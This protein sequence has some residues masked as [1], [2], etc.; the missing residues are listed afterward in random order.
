MDKLL[1]AIKKSLRAVTHSRYFKT[2][3][4][5]QGAF[6]AQLVQCL[7]SLQIEGAII[8]EEYQKRMRDHGIII[9]PDIIVHVPFDPTIHKS[10]RQGNFV[11]FELKLSPGE[12]QAQEDYRHLASMCEV[13]NYPP[14]E[15]S[16]I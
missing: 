1:D 7:P 11:V 15:F 6:Q 2:E 5:F 3:R 10:R 9:R 4:G 14:L 8:E 16:L 13:L 12:R